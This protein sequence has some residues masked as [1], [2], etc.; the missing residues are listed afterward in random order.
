MQKNAKS[1]LSFQWVVAVTPKITDKD[2]HK[3]YNNEKIHEIVWE[4]PKCDTET[5]SAQM[6]WKMV[7]TDLLGAGLPTDLWFVKSTTSF[8]QQLK[9]TKHNKACVA[10]YHDIVL[11]EIWYNEL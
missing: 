10:K 3:K 7:L 11:L 8:K 9:N 5:S 1:H 6:L 2:H 4:F